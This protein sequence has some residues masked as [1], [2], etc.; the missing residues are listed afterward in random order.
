MDNI[1]I[2]LLP[3]FITIYIC[4]ANPVQLAGVAPKAEHPTAKK[5]PQRDA[6]VVGVVPE[7][8]IN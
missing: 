8:A 1:A 6:E 3:N 5:R 7:A 4:P 2:L